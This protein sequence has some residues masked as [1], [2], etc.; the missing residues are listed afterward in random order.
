MALKL[1]PDKNT[2]PK[3]TDAFKRVSAAFSTLSDPQKKAVYDRAGSAKAYEERESMGGGSA[4][5][6][7]ANDI[8]QTFA[9]QMFQG[10]FADDEFARAF[11]GGGGGRGFRVFT[12]GNGSTTFS[13]ST[14]GPGG[15]GRMGGNHG[16]FGGDP[17]EQLL[18]GMN[19]GMRNR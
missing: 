16:G 11:R 12:T 17:I 14:S 13:F 10:G 15:F 1:H 9:S 18:R 4:P 8:F 7:N 5:N 3:A 6:F 19:G 2:A